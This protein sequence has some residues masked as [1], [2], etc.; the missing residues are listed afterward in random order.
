MKMLA[1]RSLRIVLISWALFTVHFATNVV[2]EHYPAFALA[3]HGGFRLD[4]YEGFHSDIF[5]H[6]DGHAYVCNNVAVSVLAAVP[7]WLFDPLL[8]AL[9]RHSKARLAEADAPAEPTYRTHLPNRRAFFRTVRERGL[10]LRFGAAT[11]I[12]SAFFM[13][14]FSAL[15]VLQMFHLLRRR[16]LAPGRATGL[17]FLFGFGTPVFF[18]TAHLNHNLFVMHAMFLAFALLWVRPEEQ[19]PASLGRRL[20]AG[21][22]AG[23]CLAADYVGV[24]ILPLLFGYLVLARRAT[25]S[26]WST[27]LRESSAFVLGTVPPVLFL[28]YSQWA[29]F[30]D[31]FLPA[32]FWMPEVN[33]TDVGMRG[34]AWPAPDLF[35]KNLFD[36]AY[37]LC[38]FAPLLLLAHLPAPREREPAWILPRRERRF[39]WLTFVVFLLFCAANQYARMQ[40]NTGFRYL[41]PLVPFLFLALVDPVLRLPRRWR[42]S[43]AALALLHTW[44]LTMMRVDVVASWRRFLHQGPVLPWLDVLR[45]TQPADAPV[46]SHP[47]LPAGIL[48]VVG[49]ACL[50][51]W[52]H[53]A[54][55]EARAISP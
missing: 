45:K 46:I 54:R 17:A 28:L 12:T 49:V 38:P 42:L 18:R 1:S 19:A 13:A 51:L 33:Y 9:E 25:A 41:V 26:S 31:P 20:G 29:M 39:V 43:L 23:F 32:Q 53:G 36:P 35:L 15:A 52:R 47:L 6:T 14:P 2:R 40:W 11:M 44:V 10:D 55:L 3:E 24:I 5:V 48:A 27:S 7:L 37:G 30:G 50:L 8:D 4:P 22:C 16:G 21:L 34:F